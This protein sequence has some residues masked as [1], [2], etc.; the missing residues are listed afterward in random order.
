MPKIAYIRKGF[1]IDHILI[2]DQANA[3]IEEYLEQGFTLTLRQLYY[4]FVARDFIPNT[5]KSYNRLGEIINSA[6][7]CGKVDWNAIEDRTR[8]IRK[9]PAWTHPSDILETCV[10]SF[11][12]DKWEGQQYR[13]EVWVEKDALVGILEGVCSRLN[14]AYFSCRG[15]T[16]Q[17]EM[18]RGAQRLLNIEETG[19]IPVVIHL[20][21]H[22]PSGIDMS[23]D[24]T[25]RLS[26]FMNSEFE[27][28]RIALNRDQVELYEPP[29]NPAKVTD[30][31][32]AKYVG[33]YGDES[34]ELDALE[35][36]IIDNLISRT[37]KQYLDVNAYAAKIEEENEMRS[38]L[39]LIYKKEKRRRK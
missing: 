38:R 25:D 22:D 34:W 18:W 32:Y 5:P 26:L 24:I 8:N 15:Y 9:P 13:P 6:R 3:I 23:R 30:S 19:Q 21:D 1:T 37:V 7:L 20:G 29:P 10:R 4:Q 16:S 12:I 36:K 39:D 27:V 31:R 2:I 35:P 14:I 11:Q 33:I 28:E 17:S